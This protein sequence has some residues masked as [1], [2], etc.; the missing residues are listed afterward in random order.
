MSQ[1][2]HTEEG[3]GNIA[4]NN[5]DLTMSSLSSS[6]VV[7][8]IF[9]ANGN[10]SSSVI[11]HL[12]NFECSGSDIISDYT[13]RIV[14]RDIEVLSTRQFCIKTEI[15]VGSITDI[16]R[17][18]ELLQNVNRVFFC[19]PQSLS[20]EDM[21]KTSMS[22]AKAAKR[23][24]VQ[25]VVRISSY[26][27]DNKSDTTSSQGSLGKAHVEGEEH[28]R[29]LGLTVTSVRP[30]S[31]FSNFTKYD[32]PSIK[33]YSTFYSPLGNNA[34]VNWISCDDISNVVATCLLNMSFD[35][36]I[37]DI[38]GS[39][40]NTLSAEQMRILFEAKYKKNVTYVELPLPE[41]VEMNGLWMFLRNGGFA[42]H[43]NTVERVTRKKAI[44]FSDFLDN[45]IN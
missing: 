29:A 17:L 1:M 22:F 38:T 33:S 35:G 7:I 32:D 19:L 45:Y 42:H 27:M 26:G 30:T 21:V 31:F 10:I 44:E 34:S 6:Q 39:E 41:S 37:L 28:M 3:N 36:Q 5:A 40:K 20:S 9:G 2:D 13:L 8:A 4:L 18:D 14:T 16:D 15:M 11:S 43:T 25:T 23:A 24:G 12:E